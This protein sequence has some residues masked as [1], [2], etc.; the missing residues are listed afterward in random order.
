MIL[1]KLTQGIV[2][3][4]CTALLAG[5]CAA[6]R[7]GTA[8]RET[9]KVPAPHREFRAVWVATV[10]NIDWP[11]AP[12]L[13]TDDQKREIIAILDKAQSINLNAIV[14][15]IRPQCDAFYQSAIEPWSYYLTGVQ[16]KAPDPFY[17]PLAFWI[18]EAHNRGMELHVWF[19]PYRAHHP[20][21]GEITESSVVRTHPDLV[22]Q[23]KGGYYWLDP[24][25]KGTQDHSFDVVMD[26]VRRY[27]IDGVHF[28]DYFYPYPS[29]NDGEDFPD[30]DTWAE[31]RD[32]GGKR[33][34]ED[35]RRDNVNRFIE[36]VYKAIKK[37]KPFVK[38]GLSPFGIWRPGYPESIRGF[39]QYN[40][41]YADAKLWLNRGWVDYWTPQL[42]WATN[43]IPQ[44]YPVL[45]G[46]W[47]RENTRKRNLW[48]G[49][50]TSTARDEKGVDEIINQIMITRGFV[51]GGP[52]N[53]HFSMKALLDNMGGIA[54]SLA[55]GPYRAQALV[56]TSPWLDNRAPAAPHVTTALEGVNQVISWMPGD[57]EAVFRWI[58]YIKKGDS[59]NSVILN[60]SDRSYSFSAVS[61][62]GLADDKQGGEKSPGIT[63]KV[64]CI[65]VSAVDRTGNESPRT[66]VKFDGLP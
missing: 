17:D 20:A 50:Y 58:V 49:L 41:L 3:I 8:S 52:G 5:G 25:K 2:L 46:W 32:R 33:S 56:P 31:Y 27:D 10:A 55:A 34:R 14:L 12:G 36:R 21:A 57:K 15:Q 19:N 44:S 28:D 11:S 38:F 6:L 64:S 13:S 53:V 37:E 39:D 16:G 42:Y 62:N 47:V 30:D 43:R 22:R 48:P 35:W 51:P 59:W 45:L 66:L 1:K 54:D 24:A 63:G 26:V 65:A 7:Q 61:D 29:Y 18:E 4:C 60:R 23:L 9:E 40:V